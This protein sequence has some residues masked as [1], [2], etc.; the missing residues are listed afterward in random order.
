M[1]TIISEQLVKR[2]IN[3]YS[4]WRKEQLNKIK[5]KYEQNE[6]AINSELEEIH[7]S[8]LS[9]QSNLNE[10]D[11]YFNSVINLSEVEAV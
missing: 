10:V 3:E 8:K 1:E 7:G 6:F 4:Q 2:R 11:Y 9:L 5:L